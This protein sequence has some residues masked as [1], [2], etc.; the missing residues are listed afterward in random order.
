MR[1]GI[2]LRGDLARL[3][4]PE[5]AETLRYQWN[6][7]EATQARSKSTLRLSMRGPIRHPWAYRLLSLGCVTGPGLSAYLGNIWLGLFSRERLHLIMCEIRDLQ[8]EIQSRL[9]AKRA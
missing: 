2:N 8:D 9:A 5:I 1:L 4:D 3:T 7:F 6:E